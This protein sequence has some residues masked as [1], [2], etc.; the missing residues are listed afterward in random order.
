[1]NKLKIWYNPFERCQESRL[2]SLG[3]VFYLIGSLLAFFFNMRFDNFLHIAIVE[4]VKIWQPFMDNLIII[5]CLFVILFILG[6]YLNFKTR[7]VDILSTVL[8][9]NAPFY[10]LSLSNINDINLKATNDIMSII[11]NST[12]DI[13]TFSIVYLIIIG[14]ISLLILVWTITL[15][16]NGFKTATHAKGAKPI[17]LFILALVITVV[18]TLF[19]PIIY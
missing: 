16:Y 1:M 12:Y 17:I 10:L 5:V 13:P 18:I 7:A 15:L 8:I 2:I 3:V 11:T 6:K 14:I 9:G 4:E 19:I